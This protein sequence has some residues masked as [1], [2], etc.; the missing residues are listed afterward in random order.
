MTNALIATRKRRKGPVTCNNCHKKEFAAASVKI[1]PAAFDF[2]DHNKHVKIMSRFGKNDCGQ[3]HHTFDV[4]EQK[5]ITKQGSEQSC[6]S[7]HDLKAKKGP[8]LAAITKVAAEKGL[9]VRKGFTSAVSGLS[10]G[11]SADISE[12]GQ[13]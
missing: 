8:D 3:C 9:S 12:D 2:V 10:C 1:P 7:C 4:K 6:A 5:L 11:V 13:E